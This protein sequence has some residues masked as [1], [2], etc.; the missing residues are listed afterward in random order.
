MHATWA[1]VVAG[2]RRYASYRGAMLGGALT[3]SVFGLLRASIVTAAITTAGGT[4]G[5]YGVAA[6]VTYAWITQALIGPLQIFTWDELALRVR[7]GDIAVDLIRPLDLQLQY[8]A[9]DVGRAVAIFLPR[10]A[11][12]LAVGALTFGLALPGEPLAYLAGAL[13]VVLGIGISFACRYLVNLAAIWLLDVRGLL[14]TYVTVS[15]VLC[16]LVIPVHWFPGWLATLATATPFPSMLQAPADV[17]TGRATTADLPGLLAVQAAWLVSTVAAGQ[18]V[19]RL[20][21]RRLVVQGG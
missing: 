4:L 6:G 5:G 17:L 2:F 19:Q 14:T 10:G 12:P 15:S 1:L 9:A 18:I 21:T 8:A 13:A 20:G 7:T 16:G 11:P 3:N